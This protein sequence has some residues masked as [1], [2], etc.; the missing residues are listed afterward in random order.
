MQRSIAGTNQYFPASSP[1]RWGGFRNKRNKQT[2]AADEKMKSDK[3]H[4]EKLARE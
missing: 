2:A 1:T 3:T 4:T